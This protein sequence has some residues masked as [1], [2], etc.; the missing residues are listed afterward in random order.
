MPMT[1]RARTAQPAA[2]RR[3][4]PPERARASAG[5][6]RCTDATAPGRRWRPPETTRARPCGEAQSAGA[7]RSDAQLLHGEAFLQQRVAQP[8]RM[9]STAIPGFAGLRMAVLDGRR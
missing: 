1:A 3:P 6:R 2:R 9:R 4:R 7:L 8:L 5:A